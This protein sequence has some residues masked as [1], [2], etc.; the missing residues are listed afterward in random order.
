[1]GSAG[2]YTLIREE[3]ARCHLIT[4]RQS[5][6]RSLIAYFMSELL[7]PERLQCMART[8]EHFLRHDFVRSV[9]KPGLRTVRPLQV[10]QHW[11]QFNYEDQFHV[12]SSA[13]CLSKTHLKHF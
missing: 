7:L 4:H 2:I 1:M 6:F 3:S 10:A 9:W 13:K 8:L 12:S 5:S 11:M